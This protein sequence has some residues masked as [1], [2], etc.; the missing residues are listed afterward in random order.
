MPETMSTASPQPK[1]TIS[2]VLEDPAGAIW[3]GL[4]PSRSKAG[5][6]TGAFATRLPSPQNWLTYWGDYQGRYYS[7]LKQITPS[8]VTSLQAHW[9]YQVPGGAPLEATPLV[10]DVMYSRGVLGRVF[11][12]DA[13]TGRVIWQSQRRRKM[14]NPYDSAKVNRGVAM[15]GGRL[16]FTTLTT[17][18]AYLVALDAKTG[19]PIWERRWRSISKASAA[20]WRPLQSKIKSSPASPEPNLEFAALSMPTRPQR[21]SGCG[22]STQFPGRVNSAIIPGRVIA[23]NGAAPPLG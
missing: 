9:A 5:S 6:T 18:D 14:V 20:R 10:V 19:L 12:L 22:G 3:P 13:R 17:A 16:F 7:A 21:A 2:W 11:A 4:R 23:G 1:S 8:N 15:L